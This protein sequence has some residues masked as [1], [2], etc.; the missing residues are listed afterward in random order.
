M[1]YGLSVL[2]FQYSQLKQPGMLVILLRKDNVLVL[3]KEENLCQNGNY[4]SVVSSQKPY[5]G[6][7]FGLG[8]PCVAN[9]ASIRPQLQCIP[10]CIT[11]L[12]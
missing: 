10:V 6:S 2:G 11:L 8:F 5:A 4:V 9:C 3:G 7:V 1:N 12:Q